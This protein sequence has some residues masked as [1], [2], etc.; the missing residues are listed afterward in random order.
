MHYLHKFVLYI[1]LTQGYKQPFAHIV[2]E[3]PVK[4]TIPEFWRLVMNYQVQTIVMMNPLGDE[5]VRL[6]LQQPI[7]RLSFTS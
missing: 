6:I 2:T 7:S 1:S 3:M 5:Q 4:D